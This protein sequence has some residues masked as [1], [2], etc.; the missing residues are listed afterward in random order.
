MDL[1]FRYEKQKLCD[2]FPSVQDLPKQNTASSSCG[3]MLYCMDPNV[4][5]GQS[6]KEAVQKD[7]HNLSRI[8]SVS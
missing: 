1:Y 2:G 7:L 5:Y 8:S 3:Y 6:S 4:T